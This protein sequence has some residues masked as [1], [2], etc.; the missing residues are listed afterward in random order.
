[1]FLIYQPENDQWKGPKHVVVLYVINYTYLYNHIVVLDRYTK[2]N[3]AI[4]GILPSK[5][6]PVLMSLLRVCRPIPSQVL[7][8]YNIAVCELE[9]KTPSILLICEM[10]EENSVPKIG[11]VP[12][13]VT[14]YTESPP[15]FGC[16]KDKTLRYH[17]TEYLIHI[18][19][20]YRAGERSSRS[21]PVPNKAPYFVLLTKYY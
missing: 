13:I 18:T 10:N 3:L 1:M 6:E 5:M 8:T 20:G 21:N 14:V 17:F 2:S 15:I 7:C 16:L 4:K 12:S 19:L 9:N 11:Q